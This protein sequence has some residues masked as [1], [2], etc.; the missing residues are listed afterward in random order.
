MHRAE[1]IVESFVQ[2]VKEHPRFSG[3]YKA[4]LQCMTRDENGVFRGFVE[5]PDGTKGFT[6]MLKELQPWLVA[7][8]VSV[9]VEGKLKQR[10]KFVVENVQMSN[11]VPNVVPKY[12]GSIVENILGDLNDPIWRGIYD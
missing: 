6:H 7:R 9:R 3:T 5:L 11:Q 4:L 2:F 8:G 10:L 12:K 1:L